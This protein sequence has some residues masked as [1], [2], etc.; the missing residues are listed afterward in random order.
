MSRPRPLVLIVDD[1][2]QNIRALGEA[3]RDECEILAATDGERALALANG[4]R[5]PDL[6]LLDVLMPTMDG[7]EVLRRLRGDPTTND[8]PVIFVT[9]MGEDEDET[10]GLEL[11]AVD[12]V[13][14]P[15]SPA[16]VRARV[17][18]HLA[19]VQA[20]RELSEANARM[21]AELDTVAALQKSLLP[22][23]SLAFDAASISSLYI[24]SGRASGDYFD[25]FTLP[26]GK[27]RCVVADVSGHGARAAFVMAMVR[28]LF[29]FAEDL[30]LTALIDRINRQ[31]VETVGPH[32]DYVTLFALDLDQEGGRMEYVNA[33]HCPAFAADASGL[34]ELPA[35]GFMCGVFDA[36]SLAGEAVLED[37]WRL[38]LYTDGFYEWFTGPDEVLGYDRFRDICL[39][40]LEK[41][42]FDLSSLPRI[43]SAEA[44]E[45][46]FDD[47]LTALLI[48]GG[49][50]P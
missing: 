40:L 10:R 20:R 3:L 21:A 33:G 43:I 49:A 25:C 23:G 1:V 15:F 26:G 19:L 41:P 5:R 38:L 11:G 14:K 29:R 4:E 16:V 32:G 34:R 27:L 24:P 28:S 18:G 50:R 36:P 46:H 22:S 42:G 44:P 9:A 2:P 17:R 39:P 30:P 35:T 7:H 31:L 47:D 12:Y 45:G 37:E 6:V 13:T 8:I 48:S